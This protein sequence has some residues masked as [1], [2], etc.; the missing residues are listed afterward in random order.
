MSP[1]PA[2]SALACSCQIWAMPNLPIFRAFPIFVYVPVIV[3]P[4]V[5]AE[6]AAEKIFRN[7]TFKSPSQCANCMRQKMRRATP[8]NSGVPAATCLWSAN[9]EDAPFNSDR[10][11]DDLFQAPRTTL[12]ILTGKKLFA[13][14]GQRFETGMT[15]KP[16]R[17]PA[18][19]EAFRRRGR[20]GNILSR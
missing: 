13:R 3:G 17:I 7:A 14:W 19:A 16:E 20:Y 5:N 15:R 2:A 11:P 10:M 12:T 8:S 9:M 6:S 1:I 4:V 18:R